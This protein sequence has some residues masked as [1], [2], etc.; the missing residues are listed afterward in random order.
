MVPAARTTTT[1]SAQLANKGGQPRATLTELSPANADPGLVYVSAGAVDADGYTSRLLIKWG[2]GL[3]TQFDYSL[4]SCHTGDA[5]AVNAS[6]T[7][8]TPGQYTVQLT[9]TSVACDGNGGN[10]QSASTTTLVSYS[11]PPSG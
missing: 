5:Q 7:Y 10:P 4:S 11:P 1:T 8:A 2:D 9:V 6:H 3:A